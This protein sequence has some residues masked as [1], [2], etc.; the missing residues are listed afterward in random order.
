[1]AKPCI[2]N[3]SELVFRNGELSTFRT[4]IKCLEYVNDPKLFPTLLN[5]SAISPVQLKTEIQLN[6]IGDI[7]PEG[8][9]VQ[10]DFYLTLY[11]NDDRLAMPAYWSQVDPVLQL[12]GVRLERI[13][14]DSAGWFIWVPDIFFVD[15]LS[16]VEQGKSFSINASNTVRF[17]SHIVGTFSQQHYSFYDYPRGT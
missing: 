1:M 6:N 7:D 10:L 11:W 3:E 15:G 8:A 13:F 5:G 4:F 2:Q 17:Q 16:I 12:E 9:S 14:Y